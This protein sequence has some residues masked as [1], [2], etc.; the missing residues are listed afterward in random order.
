MVLKE[1]PKPE[2]LEDKELILDFRIH[3][4][5]YTP[6]LI[7]GQQVESVSTFKYLGTHIPANLSSSPNTKALEKKAQQRLH[8][9][10]SIARRWT[11]S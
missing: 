3:K 4:P 10:P 1:Q 9:W 7:N 5:A 11:L 2:C 6:L 8:C